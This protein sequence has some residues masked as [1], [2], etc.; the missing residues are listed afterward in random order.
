MKPRYY[1]N[2]QFYNHY[3]QLH[4]AYVKAKGHGPMA[5]IKT[6]DSQGRPILVY[7]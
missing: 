4:A 2:H 6:T 7:K 1:F 5:A 3:S